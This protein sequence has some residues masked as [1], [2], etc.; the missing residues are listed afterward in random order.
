MK[1]VNKA[2]Y[3]VIYL[4]HKLNFLDHVKMVDT[5]GEHSVRILYKRKKLYQKLQLCHSLV[6]SYFIYGLTVLGNRS[7]A[8]ISKLHRLQNKAFRIVAGS[9]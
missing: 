6:H 5:K 3:L 4:D 1:S 8:Y 2:K 7:P 9:S